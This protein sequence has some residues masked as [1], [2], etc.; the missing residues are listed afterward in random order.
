LFAQLDAEFEVVVN[1]KGVWVKQK[2]EDGSLTPRIDID[3]V[4]DGTT[5]AT[6]VGLQLGVGSGSDFTPIIFD[7]QNNAITM[8]D[9]GGNSLG[10][11]GIQLVAE[12]GTGWEY[13][14]QITTNRFVLSDPDAN[15][16]YGVECTATKGDYTK[17]WIEDNFFDVTA[18]GTA[19]DINGGSLAVVVGRDNRAASGAAASI[20]GAGVSRAAA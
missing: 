9:I 5:G 15:N 18:G 17:L 19:K 8:M 6:G 11:Y 13:S 14:G 7:I 20:A 2:R 3:I 12:G 1:E 10:L 16:C 4:R